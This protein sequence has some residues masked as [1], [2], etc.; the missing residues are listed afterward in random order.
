MTQ[1]C[2]IEQPQFCLGARCQVLG[3][4][5]HNLR[6]DKIAAEAREMAARVN[7]TFVPDPEKIANYRRARCALLAK[8]GT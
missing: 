4:C 5:A 8:D 7:A 3:V 6:M 1:R 2:P